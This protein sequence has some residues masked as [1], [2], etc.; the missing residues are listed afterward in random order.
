MENLHI[1]RSPLY[2]TWIVLPKYMFKGEMTCIIASTKAAILNTDL[3]QRQAYNRAVSLKNSMSLMDTN[4]CW[5]FDT[6]QS[7]QSPILIVHPSQ[8]K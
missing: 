2:T 6:S 1:V 4:S 8:F 5:K 3:P 7:F